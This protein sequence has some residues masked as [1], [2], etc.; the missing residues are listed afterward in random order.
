MTKAAMAIEQDQLARVAP[1]EATKLE[2]FLLAEGLSYRELWLNL[3]GVPGERNVDEANRLLNEMMNAFSETVRL[4]INFHYV[5]NGEK[6]E[7]FYA[8]QFDD[9]E[10]LLIKLSPLQERGIVFRIRLLGAP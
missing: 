6:P 1:K 4:P 2:Q 5:E 10:E 3:K 9:L 8:F 7:H